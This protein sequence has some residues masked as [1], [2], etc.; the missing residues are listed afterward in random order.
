MSR[1]AE[2]YLGDTPASYPNA[3]GYK[4]GGTSRDAA[5]AVSSRAETLREKVLQ[6]L[7]TR[8]MTADEVAAFIGE[9]VLATRPRLTELSKLGLIVPTGARR[10]NE[11]GLKAREWRAA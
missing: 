1:I 8:S 4:T 11:S 2:H 5:K 10:R 6:A 7:Q 3:P 9:T